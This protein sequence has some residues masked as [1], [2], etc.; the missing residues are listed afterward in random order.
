M[1]STFMEAVSFW[2]FPL[3]F[4]A[5]LTEGPRCSTIYCFIS[6]LNI[7]ALGSMSFCQFSMLV[8]IGKLFFSTVLHVRV[9]CLFC[10]FCLFID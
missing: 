4:R 10:L 2:T 9:Y 8:F 7:V 3:S 1:Q 6:R 5:C